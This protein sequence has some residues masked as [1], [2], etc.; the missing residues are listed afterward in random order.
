[1]KQN[2]NKNITIAL[3]LSLTFL[4]VLFLF[5]LFISNAYYTNITRFYDDSRKADGFGGFALE[6][7]SNEFIVNGCGVGTMLDTLTDLCWDR[8]LN[9][10]GSTIQWSTVN[11]YEEPIWNNVT[12]VYSYPN[13]TKANYPAFAYCEDLV[14]DSNSDFRLPT[15]L[16][17]FTLIDQTGAFGSTCTTLTGFGFTNCQN[18]YYYVSSVYLPDTNYASAVTFNNGVNSA[19]LKNSLHYLVCVSS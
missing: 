10:N 17:L 2:S 6:R 18:N 19:Y 9:H 1:M 15:S 7:T 11:T 8:N 5:L 14:I 16:E 12:K 3:K 13:G 4:T